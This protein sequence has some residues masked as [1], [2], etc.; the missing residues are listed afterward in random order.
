MKKRILILALAAALT[1]SASAGVIKKTRSEVAFKGFGRLT[2]T[3]ATKLV[4]D[5]QWTDTQ[6]DFKGKGL[7]GGLAGKTVLR[8]GSFGEILDLPALTV[9]RLNPKK[10]EYTVEPIKKFEED[11]EAREEEKGKEEKPEES[12]I[13]IIRS[14]FK[15]VET[16]ETGNLN[17]FPT[18]KYVVSWIVDW[19][20]VRTGEKGTNSL[21]TDVLATPVSAAIAGAREE[22]TKFYKGYMK[23]IG[24]DQE[25][26]SGDVLGSSWMSILEGMNAAKGRPGISPDASKAAGEMGKIK[27]Y[28]V[29][30]DGKY[31]VTSDKPKES[32]ESSGGGLLGGLAKK[33]LK[34]KPSAAEAAEPAL[35]YRIETLEMGMK[36]LGAP[37]FEIPAGFKKKG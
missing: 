33:A 4:P 15:V 8:S 12:D 19:E 24:L 18:T 14:E 2:M 34:K 32:E 35:A 5:K 9:T 3:Q 20:N 7:L 22:E 25:K 36:D 16:G 1:G 21:T 11:K 30:I 27:G 26:L 29:L 37:D 28:P 31:F 10:M 23:A 6:S 17:G 13:K